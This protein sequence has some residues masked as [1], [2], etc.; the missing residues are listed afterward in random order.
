MWDVDHLMQQA[1]AERV[2]PGAVLLV[3]KKNDVRFFK[4]YGCSN[5]FSKAVVTTDT[6]FDLASL[7]K[8]LAT[9]L[10]VMLLVQRGKIQ[11]EQDLGSLLPEF[12][13]SDK[14]NIKLKHL[15]YHKQWTTTSYLPKYFLQHFR[16]G[17][18]KASKDL[19]QMLSRNFLF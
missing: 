6:V 12:E 18:S 13:N 9:A 10:A 17:I 2:F 5:I 14:S 15:L 4:A 7:T 11:L 19:K 16:E 3:S 1:I 8:P